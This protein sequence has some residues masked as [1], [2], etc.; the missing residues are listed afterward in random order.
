[1]KKSVTPEPLKFAKGELI[2]LDQ[3][4]IPE[5]KTYIRIKTACATAKAIKDMVVRGAPAIG[6]AAAYGMV[7]G[8]KNPEKSAQILI[9]A[10]PTAVNLK[11]AV[12]KMLKVKDRS[13]KTMMR[14]AILLDKENKKMCELISKNGAKLIKKSSRV[15]THCNAGP[16]ATGGIGTALGIIFAARKNIETVYVKETR[17]RLQGARLTAWE[18]KQWRIPCLLISDGMAAHIMK[19][20]RVDAVIVGADRIASNGDSANKIGTYA[21]AISAKYHK[22]PF[23]VAAPYSTIDFSAKSGKDI[24]IEE[25]DE[26]EMLFLCGKCISAPGVKALNP[27]F[28][29]T[30]S[31][32][33]TAIIT[34]RGVII[35]PCEKNIRKFYS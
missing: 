35:N 16:L 10:R 25:R 34:E 18:L 7:L 29:V 1:M 6:V 28:D 26:K 32:L 21:L 30:P 22:V 15:M 23:Y 33:I 24:K 3:R 11:W 20:K 2:L 13:F 9:A 5:K 14:E 27:S 8:R 4:K 17:P 19:T 12:Q 31:S